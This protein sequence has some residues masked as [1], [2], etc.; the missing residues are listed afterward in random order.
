MDYRQL[1]SVRV[2][3][4]SKLND[5]FVKYEWVV[6]CCFVTK[7]R[8]HGLWPARLL[9]PWNSLGKNTRVRWHFLLQG[10]F[11]IELM[12]GGFFTPEAPGK[13]RTKIKTTSLRIENRNTSRT[14]GESLQLNV[15]SIGGECERCHTASWNQIIIFKLRR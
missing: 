12:A 10:I 6:A 11:P 14:M 4:E 1:K 7:S 5:V 3:G 13:P 15:C 8:P 2:V 9:C